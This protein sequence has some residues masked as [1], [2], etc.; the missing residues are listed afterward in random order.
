MSFTETMLKQISPK[1]FESTG[2]QNRYLTTL[3]SEEFNPKQANLVG[4]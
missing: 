3:V 1:K 2:S 4:V